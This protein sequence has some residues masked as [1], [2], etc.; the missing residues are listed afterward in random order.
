MFH[1]DSSSHIRVSCK[2][3]SKRISCLKGH[4]YGL[5]IRTSKKALSF[6]LPQNPFAEM[7]RRA[8]SSLFAV[9]PDSVPPLSGCNASSTPTSWHTCNIRQA[10]K[11]LT[12][13]CHEIQMPITESGENSKVNT[14]HNLLLKEQTSKRGGTD[15]QCP[16]PQICHWRTTLFLMNTIAWALPWYYSCPSG[17]IFYSGIFLF[18]LYQYLACMCLWVVRQLSMDE[19]QR[20]KEDHPSLLAMLLCDGAERIQS[21][22]CYD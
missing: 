15:P 6:L 20:K 16:P 10:V 8:L 13:L 22:R 4:I 9:A 7:S 12:S 18:A 1:I 5:K 14:I 21:T 2:C 19:C 11:S 17:S 3:S